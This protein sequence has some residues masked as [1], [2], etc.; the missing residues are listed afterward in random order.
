MSIDPDTKDWTWVIERPC[1]DCGFDPGTVDGP[2]LPDL[3]HDN[4]RGWYDVLDRADVGVR[5]AAHIWS[6]LEYAAHVR[7]VH[8]LFAQRVAAMV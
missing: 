2:A 7:D 3:I 8:R 6:P 4:T 1:P 5:P